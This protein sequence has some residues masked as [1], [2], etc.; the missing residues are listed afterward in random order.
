M[1]NILL[2]TKI[3]SVNLSNP[4]YYDKY[5]MKKKYQSCI[6]LA[7]LLRMRHAFV[8]HHL[9]LHVFFLLA[10]KNRSIINLSANWIQKIIVSVGMFLIFP[11][12]Q[13]FIVLFL[14]EMKLDKFGPR[15][16]TL[17]N[18]LRKKIPSNKSK[19]VQ[20]SNEEHNI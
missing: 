18:H 8:A 17:E 5:S 20:I 19:N 12:K 6:E 16:S 15:N 3:S 4:D 1:M 9:R 2:V 7:H 11:N 14:E 13:W 10:M